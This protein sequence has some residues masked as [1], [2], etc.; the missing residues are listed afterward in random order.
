[1]SEPETRSID[2]L[3]GAEQSPRQAAKNNRIA[4]IEGW[5]SSE[6]SHGPVPAIEM[7]SKAKEH[8]YSERNVRAAQKALKVEAEIPG[9]Q[10]NWHWR[11]PVEE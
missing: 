11:L 4:E 7:W 3:F 9:F 10:G 5:L 1:M 2:E 6:L 8:G